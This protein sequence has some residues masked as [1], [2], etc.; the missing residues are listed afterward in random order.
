MH[1]IKTVVKNADQKHVEGSAWHRGQ[2]MEGLRKENNPA[3]TLAVLVNRTSCGLG[4][5]GGL[6]GRTTCISQ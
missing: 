1:V 4:E 6:V 5:G 3:I 2:E